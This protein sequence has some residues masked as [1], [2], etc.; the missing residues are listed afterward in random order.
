VPTA[1]QISLLSQLWNSSLPQAISKN[2]F[3]QS[4]L[5]SL[6]VWRLPAERDHVPE[7]TTGPFP[8]LSFPRLRSFLL[9]VTLPVSRLEN[10]LGQSTFPCLQDAT[11]WLSTIIDSVEPIPAEVTSPYSL[12]MPRLRSLELRVDL[13]WSVLRIL[14]LFSRTSTEKLIIKVEKDSSKVD[15]SQVIMF[16][17]HLCNILSCFRPP[18]K[19]D[20]Y[21]PTY[22]YLHLFLDSL[23][24]DSVNNL[25]ISIRD[26]SIL[27]G[28][29]DHKENEPEITNL[30]SPNLAE[31]DVTCM[32]LAVAID[33][34]S[35][36]Q[37]S[38][39]RTLSIQSTMTGEQ[40]VPIHTDHLGTLL[41]SLHSI[42]FHLDYKEIPHI[43]N[44]S[45]LAPNV[46]ILAINT[47]HGAYRLDR[48]PNA[49]QD[50]C[51]SFT[52]LCS[53]LM[54]GDEGIPFPYLND[55]EGQLPVLYSGEAR[56]SDVQ[57][58][59]GAADELSG[60]IR[61][62]LVDLL[63]SREGAGGVLLQIMD[64]SVRLD[65]YLEPR[66]TLFIAEFKIVATR[67]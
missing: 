22:T 11:L 1:Q 46:E 8:H 44:L 7:L 30:S 26:E 18:M 34:I 19:L 24:F 4:S 66:G 42:N 29:L 28:L 3:L 63:K 62:M 13:S 21:L 27:H 23:N 31:L 53:S 16:N 2:P 56:H 35:K 43:R 45:G 52:R 51:L 39:L 32:N 20:L 47:T 57:N 64:L 65:H 48:D 59:D 5:V 14:D 50:G 55:F 12:H 40:L 61:C 60:H 15:D 37:P 36:F 25:R 38:A 54:P 17:H 58:V 33:L 49:L 10:F 6:A 41:P 9:D 67:E